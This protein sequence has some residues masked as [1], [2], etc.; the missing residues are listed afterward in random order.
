MEI[1]KD[2]W[3]YQSSLHVAKAIIIRDFHHSIRKHFA[4]VKIEKSKT[5]KILRNKQ[6]SKNKL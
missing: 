5:Q 3:G 6:F 2:Q 1:S 4:L